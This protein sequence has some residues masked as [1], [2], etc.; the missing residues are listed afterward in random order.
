MNNVLNLASQR[1]LEKEVMDYIP[2]FPAT[3]AES[4]KKCL[5]VMN[6]EQY[7]YF[8]YAMYHYTLDSEAK[9]IHAS[10]RCTDPEL[11]EYFE[12]MAREERGHYRMAQKDIEQFGI[13]V[14]GT[15]TPGPVKDFVNY[16]YEL[17]G[18]DECEYLGAMFVFESVASLCAEEVKAMI[19][20]LGLNKKQARW[21]LVHLEADEDHGAEALKMCRK[22]VGRNPQALL[23]AA[24]NGADKWIAVFEDALTNTFDAQKAA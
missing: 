10:K 22:F 12:E 1:L 16:W 24:Q 2:A 19:N 5:E 14:V 23:C 18:T 17:G 15:I 9:L 3:A 20:R 6:L 11:K 13:D 8:L 21:L 4:V 7:K